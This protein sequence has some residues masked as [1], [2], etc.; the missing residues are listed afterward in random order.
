[1]SSR[2]DSR[3]P[4]CGEPQVTQCPCQHYTPAE[5]VEV[6]MKEQD[7]MFGTEGGAQ[8]LMQ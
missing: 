4:K 1:M 3:C 8:R 2:P 5:W 7:S 6:S